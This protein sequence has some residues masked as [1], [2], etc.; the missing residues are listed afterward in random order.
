[1][2][3][4]VDQALDPGPYQRARAHRTRLNCNK[5]F[6]VSQAM[7][8]NCC[9]RLAQCQYLRMCRWIAIGDVAVPSAANDLPAAYDHP[10]R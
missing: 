2:V 4:T 1:M 5:Q 8:T 3:G 6:A 9:T 10:A 7:V